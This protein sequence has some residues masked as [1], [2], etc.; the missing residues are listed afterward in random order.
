MITDNSF[1]MMIAATI[2]FSSLVGGLAYAKNTDGRTVVLA[3]NGNSSGGGGSELEAKFRIDLV[4]E[5]ITKV[6]KHK[7]ANLL[8]SADLLQE[9]MN[10]TQVRFVDRLVDP[11]THQPLM[12]QKLDAYTVPGDI[13]L[14]LSSWTQFLTSGY[15]SSSRPVQALALHEVYRATGRDLPG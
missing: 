7:S 12:D 6:R 15:R 11:T 4:G 3:A 14:L 1:R 2:S 5:L 13:Q 8:C 9:T 10:S